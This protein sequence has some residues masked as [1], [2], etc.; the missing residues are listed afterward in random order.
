MPEDWGETE[1]GWYLVRRTE[2]FYVHRPSDRLRR[3]SYENALRT[4]R[5]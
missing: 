2:L 4:R 5:L 1:L 3:K